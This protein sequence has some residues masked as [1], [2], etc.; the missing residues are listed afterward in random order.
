MTTLTRSV[1]ERILAN[2]TVPEKISL[3]HQH[4]PAIPREGLAYFHTGAEAAH[5]VAWLGEA[6][7]FPQTVGLAATWD[8]DLLQRVGRAVGEEM[9]AK[10]A[11][12]P[13]VSLNVWAPVVNP[14]RHP[15]W[16]R[17]EEGFSEDSRLTAK[18]STAYCAGLKGDHPDQWLTVPTLKHFLGYNNE[19]DRNVTS[20]QLSPRVLHEYELPA[21]R[22]AVESSVAGAVMLSYNLVNGR[23]AHV[24]DLVAEHLRA[25]DNGE[26]LAIVTDAG[27]PS[28]LFKAEKY[29]HDGPSA[30][31]AAL[32]AGVDS[33]TDDG[34][35]PAPSV[36]YLEEALAR[37]LITEGDIDA[38]VSRLLALR[39]RTGEFLPDG[40]VYGA[41]GKEAL[42]TVGHAALAR[43]ASRKS[44]VLLR[45]SPVDD[46]QVLP[47]AEDPGK[48]AVIGVLGSRVLSDWYSGTLA[49]PV[50]IAEGLAERYDGVFSEEGLD[51]VALR[52]N[53]TNRYLGVPDNSGSLT[54]ALTN[55]GPAGSFL[56][57]D[58]GNGEYTLRSSLTGR[59]VSGEDGYLRATSGR[60]GGWVVQETFGLHRATDGS[61]ALRHVASGK[62]VRIE[63]GTGSAVL[64]PGVEADADRFSTRLIRSGHEAARK[65]AAEADVAVVVVGN[66]PHLGGR[67]TLDRSTLELPQTEQELIRVVRE[68]N[69]RTVL[70][71]VS[72]YP[73]ALGDLAETPAIVWTSH[74]GQELGRGVTDVLSG[75]HEPQGRL[76]QTWWAD[77]ADLPDILDYDIIGSRS[78]YLYSEAEPLYPF[79]HGMGYAGVTYRSVELAGDGNVR[80]TVSNDGDRA[81]SEVV[82]VYGTSDRPGF[83]RRMLLGYSRVS[84]APG[85]LTPVDVRFEVQHLATYSL[86]A[87]RMIVEPGN[88]SLLVGR[89]AVNLPLSVELDVAG[90]AGPPR[91]RG[92]WV[93][94]ELF[95]QSSSLQ[96]VPESPL[97][98]TAIA[99]AHSA[100][101]HAAAVYSG[102]TGFAPGYLGLRIV[103]CDG[104]NVRVQ[105]AGQAGTWRDWAA[106]SVGA[107]FSGEVELQ[108]PEAPSGMPASFR[109]LLEGRVTISDLLVP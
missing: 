109:I 61:V 97:R 75:D 62:W 81:V 76:A 2:L 78:T 68:A 19:L 47:L 33:F 50:S 12:D 28:A 46:M 96:L 45:N 106:T 43:E 66:D 13:T 63:E 38:A 82:Q 23:P 105:A 5:G 8:E 39:E 103:S 101:P 35:D 89:S 58:W 41:I 11:A 32:R 29:F 55:A 73:Y 6:T 98:G 31:A 102:W 74:G 90:E 92:E 94:A 52:S 71:I 64:V 83:P 91:P 48:V 104:A 17:N 65:A 99:P 69:P 57:K 79:G 100:R 95:D 16:G 3:L 85:E 86:T 4:A 93:R 10:K 21:Y 18:L 26:S 9:R 34:D 1:S 88:Y 40:G 84:L 72:S 60:V 25:W 20:S 108:L 53:R 22:L 24:S 54:A 107:G 51:T 59:F 56:L 80:V 15:L 49:N 67:E 27:A 77:N 42:L 7:V 37:G 87:Q 30:Y 44:V 70:L 36:S 14:L